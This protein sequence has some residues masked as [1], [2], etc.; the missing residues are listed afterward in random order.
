[1]LIGTVGFMLIENWSF[2]QSLY[3]TVL[4]LTTVGYSD[5][6]MSDQGKLFATGLMIGGLAVVTVCAGRLL[7]PLFSRQ[8]IWER[9]MNHRI[10]KLENHFI[11]CGLGRIG[12]A[13]CR[14]LAREGVPFIGIDPDPAA[15][16]KLIS[17]DHLAL[18]GDATDDELLEEA[19]VGRAKAI[20]CVTGSDS[21]N[22]VTILSARERRPDLMIVSR[23]EKFDAIR[24]MQK[25]GATKVISPVRSGGECIV[26]AIL[27]PN[28]AEFLD[29]THDHGEDFEL[30][31]ITIEPKS[32]LDGKTIRSF[33][34]EFEHVLVI[35]LNRADGPHPDS[36]EPG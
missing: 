2:I 24:K 31:E 25:A 21:E 19:G 27:K 23:A 17:A 6:G 4:T 15:V 8:L 14:Q 36:S 29:M 3:F 32:I 18:V 1:M 5:Y 28:L 12:Q 35:A 10:L 22:I 13:V 30:A 34:A 33:G 16:E 7:P 9:K 26:N 11:V 20:A